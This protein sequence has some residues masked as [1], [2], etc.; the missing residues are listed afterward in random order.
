[1]KAR[2]SISAAIIIYALVTAV[3]LFAVL[4]TSGYALQQL[5]I[6]GPLY[7]QIKL[8][9]DLV[10][11]ILPPPEYV[12]EA[13]LEATLAVRDP[14]AVKARGNRLVQLHKDYDERRDYWIKSDLEQSL[15]S[16]LTKASD[17]EVQR[18]WT[19]IEQEMLP[20]LEKNNG[21]AETAYAKL[22]PVYA[23]HRAIIDD[24][25]KQTND[26]NAALETTAAQRVTSFS[27]IVWSVSGVVVLI[28]TLGILGIALGVIRPVV[29]MTAVMKRL[30]QGDLD[31]EIPSAARKDEIGQMAQTVEVFK[32]STIEN[33]KL[34][35]HQRQSAEDA[36]EAKR[37]AML[38]MADAV[39]HETTKS[40]QSISTATK[41]VDVAARGLTVLATTLSS[42]SQAVAAASEQSLANAQ[43]VSAAA[44]QL[45]ASIREIG[46]QIE[47]A[48]Q[49]TGNAVRSGHRAQETIQSLS[50]VVTKIA[51]MSGNI[52]SIASQTNLL[53]LNAT[54]E[55]ARAG[56]AG[57]GF[58]VVASEVKSLSHQTAQSTE[59]INRLVA[60]IQAATE[61]A[62]T[63]VGQIG[64]EIGEVDRV[65]SSIAAAIQQQ[66]AATREIARSVDQSAQSSREVSSRIANVSGGAEEV[67]IRAVEVQGAIAN[68]S[69]NIAA[70]RS[71][72]V[73][74]VRTSSEDADRRV[75][76][77][78]RIDVPLTVTHSRGS[79]TASKLIDISQGGAR[80]ASVPD[81][82]LRD[83]CTLHIGGV[84]A[85][86]AFIVRDKTEHHTLLEL[87]AEGETREQYLS[88]LHRETSG[89]VAA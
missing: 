21:A 32:T 88:W 55:A 81:L 39:E 60:E 25:V 36:T 76:P 33:V 8:G 62:A 56:E 72:L 59:E 20:A 78:F 66:S 63:S 54:I 5:R 22:D 44:E 57:R 45:T 74:V 4:F 1:M 7:T 34:R 89:L 77:R 49:V 52:G 23:A 80:I 51:E 15:K 24:I 31:V 27:Y 40:V 48:S 11:D 67:S 70:L 83:G 75:F 35:E 82:N 65:A 86:I 73:R 79:R 13:Y 85:P 68:A 50:A 87:A 28:I 29:R 30:A 53:A 41:G 3:G 61:A 9:N 16:K 18:F 14:S 71:I 10:A 58:A 47:R 6:G 26:E 42:D 38:K 43:T 84:A 64:Q 37:S 12:L 19:I 2:I 46:S 17:T 69:A